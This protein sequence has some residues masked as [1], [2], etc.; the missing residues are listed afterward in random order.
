MKHND[1]LIRGKSISITNKRNQF[2][3]QHLVWKSIEVM[4]RFELGHCKVDHLVF[5][6][7]SDYFHIILA[8]YIDDNGITR[9][10]TGGIKWLKKFIGKHSYTEDLGLIKYLGIKVASCNIY[11][12]GQRMSDKICHV[13]IK[14]NR[15]DEVETGWTD[16]N[17]KLNRTRRNTRWSWEAWMACGKV[18]SPSIQIPW[19]SHSK[20]VLQILRYL[21]GAPSLGIIYIQH[22]HLQI[23]RHTDVDW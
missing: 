20:V 15:N 14:W 2:M 9:S 7:S 19:K 4:S 8:M 21:E 3:E 22:G 11:R 18:I 12:G 6:K 10:A 16:P 5:I 17:T 13:S 1:L 23:E